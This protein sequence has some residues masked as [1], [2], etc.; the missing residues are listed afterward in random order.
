M[1]KVSDQPVA[2][3]SVEH[4]VRNKRTVGRP[5]DLADFDGLERP[6]KRNP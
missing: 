3:L 6:E 1:T 2:V 5:Q 4:L